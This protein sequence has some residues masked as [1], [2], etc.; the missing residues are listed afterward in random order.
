V[1]GRPTDEIQAAKQRYVNQVNSYVA[2]K[3]TAAA[4]LRA[5]AAQP[6]GGAAASTSGYPGAPLSGEPQAQKQVQG[7]R[8]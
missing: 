1:D 2:R 3:K 7:A 8:A 5:N 4:D 6:L